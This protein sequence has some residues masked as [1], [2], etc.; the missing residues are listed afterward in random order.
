MRKICAALALLSL[1]ILSS[2]AE[3]RSA[4]SML[5]ELVSGYGAV[6]TVFSEEVAEGEAGYAHDGFFEMIFENPP[7]PE[8]EW[9]V[10]LSSSIDYGGE[11]G[12]FVARDTSSELYATDLVLSRIH[13]LQDIGYAKDYVLIRR[14]GVVF[15][16]TL[17]DTAL[18]AR[19]FKRI[20]LTE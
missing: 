7:D 16:S 12:V 15:Y 14:G 9:A 8:T 3:V 17:P 6:G 5:F 4:H 13:F 20:D 2:C 11:C 10:F 1:V 19:L 18:A